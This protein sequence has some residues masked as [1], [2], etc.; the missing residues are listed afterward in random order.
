[1]GLAVAVDIGLQE[2]LLKSKSYQSW[3]TAAFFARY[4]FKTDWHIVSRIEYFN[5]PREFIITSNNVNH[6]GL[7]TGAY[8]LG[9]DDS[10]FEKVLCYG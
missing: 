4:Q 2:T 5:A 9:C 6:R 8:S 1:L 10:P 3:Q 7:G